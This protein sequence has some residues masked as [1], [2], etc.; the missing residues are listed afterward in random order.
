MCG[1]Y[2]TV[3]HSGPV[4][5]DLIAAAAALENRGPQSAALVTVQQGQ[6][7]PFHKAAPAEIAFFGLK[8]DNFPGQSGICH[9]RYA[10]TGQDTPEAIDRNARPPMGDITLV[11]NGDTVNAEIL[12]TELAQAGRM[13]HT[14]TDTEVIHMIIERAFRLRQVARTKSDR[15]YAQRVFA[16]LRS[17]QPQLVGAWSILILTARGLIAW[18]GPAGIRPLL[19]A[20]RQEVAG[21]TTEVAFASESSAFNRLGGYRRIRDVPAGTAVFVPHTLERC[22]IERLSWRQEKFCLFEFVY[23]ARPDSRFGGIRVEVVRDQAGVQLAKQYDATV[24]GTFDI[25]VPVPDCPQSTAASFAATFG[26]PV[27]HAI[28]KV[29]NKRSFLQTSAEKRRKAIS[30]KFIFIREFIGG[31]RIALV[32]DS[33]VRGATL[34]KLLRHLFLLGAAEVHLF[35]ACPEIIGPCYYGIDTPDDH[36][37]LAWHHNQQRPRTRAEIVDELLIETCQGLSD[38]DRASRHQQVSIHY[39]SLERLAVAIG[40]PANQLCLG[41]LTRHY[42]TP[43]DGVELKRERWI[44]DRTL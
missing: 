12:R 17:V 3:R 5:G 36:A 32:D 13:F 20:E 2:G 33:L 39:L 22:Y 42:P 26:V 34:G 27:K 21:V 4:V 31:Q 43:T 24:R 18:R 15:T 8:P 9:T 38:A 29:G 14:Q 1:I 28:R 37:L 19:M 23:L 40:R 30:D 16:A 41:C 7:H 35:L 11:H 6:F 10:T 44:A 25:V